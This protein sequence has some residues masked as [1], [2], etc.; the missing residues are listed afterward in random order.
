MILVSTFL[1]FKGKTLV[2]LSLVNTDFWDL[3]MSW[4]ISENK[5]TGYNIKITKRSKNAKNQTLKK[6]NT[7]TT[8]KTN[9]KSFDIHQQVTQQIK[10]P[11]KN[12]TIYIK[13]HSYLPTVVYI[14]LCPFTVFITWSILWW[15]IL[16]I[17]YLDESPAKKNW[18]LHLSQNKR[19]LIFFIHTYW[20][21]YKVCS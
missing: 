16:R 13:Q 18:M 12:E 11:D 1:L 21:I 3:Y 14:W 8:K 2:F 19:K 4:Q 20:Y 15:C 10:I 9:N 17:S 5:K 6:K 7:H